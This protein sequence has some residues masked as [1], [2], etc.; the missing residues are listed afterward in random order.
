MSSI[1]GRF[2]IVFNGEI[3]NF[4]E[5]KKQLQQKGARFKNETDTEVIIEAYRYWGTKCTK[6][7][8]GMWAFALYDREKN[9]V[10]SHG[11]VSA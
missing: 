2:V 10:F 1:D 11:T 3:Y 8:N 5:L 6:R 7:F 9:S 4:V